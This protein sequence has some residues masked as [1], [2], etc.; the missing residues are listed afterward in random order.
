[1][2]AAQ[3]EA[4][5]WGVSGAAMVVMEACVALTDVR[6]AEQPENPGNPE[7]VSVHGFNRGGPTGSRPRTWAGASADWE[8]RVLSASG[9]EAVGAPCAWNQRW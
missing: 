3:G 5:E 2:E 7:R 8:P 1:M 4:K 9:P 6:L